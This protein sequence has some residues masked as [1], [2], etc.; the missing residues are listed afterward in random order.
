MG[1]LLFFV[2]WQI[3]KPICYVFNFLLYLAVGFQSGVAEDIGVSQPTVSNVVHLVSQKI[4]E[5]S[6]IWIKFPHVWLYFRC[7]LFN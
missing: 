4:I 7:Y 5:K 1:L 2:H 3:L 6:H